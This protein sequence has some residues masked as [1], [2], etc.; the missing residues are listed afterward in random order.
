MDRDVNQLGYSPKMLQSLGT[1]KNPQTSLKGLVVPMLWC[2]RVRLM[3][4]KAFFSINKLSL[5]FQFILNDYQ[6]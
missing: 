3:D 4:V 2:K 1:L 5:L 6:P